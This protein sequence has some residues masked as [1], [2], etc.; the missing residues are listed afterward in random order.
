MALSRPSEAS[1]EVGAV[2][3]ASFQTAAFL[4]DRNSASDSGQTMGSLIGFCGGVREAGEVAIRWGE[5]ITE[6]SPLLQERSSL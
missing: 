6:V 1:A 3:G 5:E 4:C 2:G